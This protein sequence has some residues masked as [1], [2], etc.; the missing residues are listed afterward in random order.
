MCAVSTHYGNLQSALSM[1]VSRLEKMHEYTSAVARGEAQVSREA[2]RRIQSVLDHLPAVSGQ[3]YYRALRAEQ[4]DA[5]SS[6][7][8]ASMTQGLVEAGEL[9]EKFGVVN[10]KGGGRRR[11]GYGG[12]LAG[13][14]LA[15]G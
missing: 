15:I 11:G 13:R 1:L 6:V 7:S 12:V 9:V 10:E 5:L 2:L 8:L 3:E 4:A 14:G